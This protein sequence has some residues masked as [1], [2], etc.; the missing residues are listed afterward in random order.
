MFCR[1]RYQLL[2]LMVMDQFGNGQPVQYSVNERNA[3][4]YMVKAIEHFQAM[5]EWERTIVVMVDKD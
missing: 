3:D 2:T 4:W 5:N 1:K